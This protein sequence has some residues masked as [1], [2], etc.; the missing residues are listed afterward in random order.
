MRHNDPKMSNSQRH[1]PTHITADVLQIPE[2]VER[3]RKAKLR[4]C[5]Q[6]LL[7]WYA[8]HG[9][10]FTW[11]SQAPSIYRKIVAEVLLQ[12]TQA[13]TVDKFCSAFFEQFGSW[14]DIHAANL[15]VLG[16]SLRPIGLWRRRAAALK[17]LAAE[18]VSRRG[19]FPSR[20][21]ELQALPAVGQYVANAILLFAHGKPRPLLD[22]NMA[23]V[24]ERVFEPRKLVDI[25][26]DA[27]LQALAHDFV[28]SRRAV[29]LNWAV[30]DVAARYCRRTS[31][32]C[33]VC[34][35]RNRC[36]YASANGGPRLVDQT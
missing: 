10:K 21:D 31:P 14:K 8:E 29:E 26:Y 34:P 13:V 22:A 1:S 7:C 4:W 28:R 15:A 24:L 32:L 20:E 36:N 16:K 19:R 9:R 35:L 6:R 27:G 5:R 25:R 23:R 2:T 17:A 3:S 12:R 33:S 30:L 18:M 11:R